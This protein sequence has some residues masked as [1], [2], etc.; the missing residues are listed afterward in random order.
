MGAVFLLALLLTPALA[1]TRVM[2]QAF[3][4]RNNLRQLIH[5]WRMYAEDN[6]GKLPNSFDWVS[7]YESYSTGNPDNTN[8]NLL[9]NSRLGPYVK[10]TA[11]FKCPAD[12]SW[13]TI[14]TIKFARVRTLSMSQSFTASNEGHLED[15]DSP[16]NTWRHYLK[17]TEMVLP[18]P[19]NLWVLIEENPDS[20]NDGAFAVGMGNN[21]FG[22]TKWQDGP[23]MLH[24]GSCGFA[25]ADGH[26]ELRKW[27]DNR[28]LAPNVTYTT[29]F[30]YGITQPYNSDIQWVRDRT[31]A[32]K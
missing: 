27:T 1:R 13:G 5:G 30:P 17:D 18:A 24:D 19:A 25:F 21:N 22:I 7:G 2:D 8:V 14:G 15:S 29:R 26:C 28:T 3:Q 12:M 31:T 11:V 20:V 32:R 6:S 9:A 16:P 4:C 23:N 10:N